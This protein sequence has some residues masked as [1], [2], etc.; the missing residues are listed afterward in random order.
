[1]EPTMEVD[2]ESLFVLMGKEGKALS[3]NFESSSEL[4]DYTGPEYRFKTLNINDL[5]IVYSISNHYFIFA[6]SIESIENVLWKIE[7]FMEGKVL[8]KDL[9]IG[10]EGSQIELLQKWLVR[11]LESYDSKLIT[12][13][14]GQT[15]KTAVI[16]FQDKYAEDVLIPQG[17]PQGTGI[18]DLLTRRKLNDLYSDF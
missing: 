15:T 5:G 8:T 11:D 9:K 7:D 4:T 10:D 1:M 12:G 14:F 6:S 16:S 2:F 18:V 17:L 3:P 13:S